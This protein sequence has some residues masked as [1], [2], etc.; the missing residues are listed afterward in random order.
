M[1]PAAVPFEIGLHAR[2]RNPT[3]AAAYLT[4]AMGDEEPVV[5][6]QALRHVA[7]AHGEF[8]LQDRHV[9]I[10]AVGVRWGAETLGEDHALNEHAGLAEL[11]DDEGGQCIAFHVLGDD[12]DRLALAERHWTE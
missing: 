7:E 3:Y 6:L 11:V 1:K 5:Y 8:A 4:A 10:D 9:A 2:L 12:N